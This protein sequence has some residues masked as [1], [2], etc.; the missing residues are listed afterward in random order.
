M[1]MGNV[2]RKMNGSCNIFL[3]SAV[4]IAFFAV[5]PSILPAVEGDGASKAVIKQHNIE[6]DYNFLSSLI[7]FCSLSLLSAER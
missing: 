3:F 5:S 6:I 2:K 1:K 7:L 4:L